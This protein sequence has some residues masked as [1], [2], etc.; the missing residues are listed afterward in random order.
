MVLIKHKQGGVFLPKY[1]IHFPKDEAIDIKDEKL[2]VKILRNID[3]EK[4][5]TKRA[6]RGED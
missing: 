5:E 2:A 3:F 4:V 1:N 6:K